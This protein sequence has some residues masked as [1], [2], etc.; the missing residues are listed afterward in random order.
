M[1]MKEHVKV[2]AKCDRC[3]KLMERHDRFHYRI[4]KVKAETTSYFADIDNNYTSWYE[5]KHRLELCPDCID[6]FKHNYIRW[7]SEGEKKNDRMG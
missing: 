7:L 3:G 5:I 4:L 2:M 6:S 1:K